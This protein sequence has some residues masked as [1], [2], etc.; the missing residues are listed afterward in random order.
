MINLKELKELSSTLNI[1]YAED[2]AMLRDSMQSTLEKLFKNVYTATNGQEAIELYKK[3]EIDLTLTDINMPIMDGIELI[4]AINK[5]DSNPAIIVLSAHDESRLLKTLINMEVNNFLNK[6]VEKDALTKILYKNC[7]ILSDKKMMKL[8]AASLEQ[9][10]DEMV[11]KNK[12]LEF[13]LKQLVSQTNKVHKQN[14]DNNENIENKISPEIKT[15]PIKDISYFS[16]LL[17]DDKDELKDLAEELDTNILLMF[18]NETLNISYTQKLAGLYKKYASVLSSYSEFYGISHTLI[19]F[20]D[21]ITQ[22]NQKFLEDME[23]TGIYL[24]SLQLTFES[25]R[26]DTWEKEAKDPCFYNA[27][28]NNDIQLIIDYL[29]GTEAEENEIEFF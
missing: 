4:A 13:K 24:E 10:N 7:S 6:P 14:Q 22:L 1:L 26:K 20:A 19:N 25:F 9:E 23:Q 8:Y 12:L 28:L 16:T 3:E 15:K 18:Q 29:E 2:E 17:Q 27:S 21:S 11:R 5:L